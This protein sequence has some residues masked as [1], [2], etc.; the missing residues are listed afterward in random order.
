M[1]LRLG[2]SPPHCAW[3]PMGSSSTL[4]ENPLPL[5][6]VLSCGHPPIP[7][8]GVPKNSLVPPVTMCSL[9]SSSLFPLGI[10]AP[11]LTVTG[12]PG[13]SIIIQLPTEAS[14][15]GL[16]T[17]P[18]AAPSAS[19]WGLLAAV[20]LPMLPHLLLLFPCLL[21]PLLYSVLLALHQ[22]VKST[23]AGPCSSIS[24]GMLLPVQQTSHQAVG[25]AILL[26]GP[27]GWP[28]QPQWHHQEMP[29]DW[30]SAF[31]LV[32]AWKP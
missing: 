23:V 22:P 18:S 20:L 15:L 7:Y 32:W 24:N 2:S 5:P 14:H 10:K 8:P 19:F 16:W 3:V 29:N 11:I 30:V 25:R 17:T 13:S 6:L 9:L 26:I 12:C 4:G 31:G 1:H 21:E 28:S 27:M